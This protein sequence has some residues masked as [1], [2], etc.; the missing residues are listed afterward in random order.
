MNRLFFLIEENAPRRV[1]IINESG[2]AIIERKLARDNRQMIG[3]VNGYISYL[4]TV[5]NIDVDQMI[6]TQSDWYSCWNQYMELAVKRQIVPVDDVIDYAYERTLTE[7]DSVMC[8][9]Q[10]G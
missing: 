10:C 5:A 2:K 6:D 3:C 4:K 9:L 8:E 7:A 1:A